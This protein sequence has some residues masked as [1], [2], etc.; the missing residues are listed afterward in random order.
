M[1]K[2]QTATNKWKLQPLVCFHFFLFLFFCI[3]QFGLSAFFLAFLLAVA[4]C[5]AKFVVSMWLGC[6]IVVNEPPLEWLCVSGD[7]CLSSR[8][9]FV[10]ANGAT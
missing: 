2:K 1:A 3:F 7:I 4:L 10:P 9:L 6:E 5:G 8:K